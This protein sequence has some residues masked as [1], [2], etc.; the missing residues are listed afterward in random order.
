M[1]NKGGFGDDRQGGGKQVGWIRVGS[2]IEGGI[3][4]GGATASLADVRDEWSG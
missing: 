4:G 1:H 2:E 3:E